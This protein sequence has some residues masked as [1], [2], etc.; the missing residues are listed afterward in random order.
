[1]DIKQSKYAK[2]CQEITYLGNHVTKIY[3]DMQKNY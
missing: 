3:R 1:M 2:K